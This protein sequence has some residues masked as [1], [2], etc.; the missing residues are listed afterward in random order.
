MAKRLV[1]RNCIP[2]LILCSSAKRTQETA[3]YF[4][5]AFGFGE[6]KLWV[7]KSLYLCTPETMLEQLAIAESG[8]RHIMIIAHNP[9]LEQLSYRLSA[10][11][12]PSMP[13]LG[14]RHFAC[15]SLN[16]L[17]MANRSHGSAAKSDTNIELV[18][19]DFPKNV[20]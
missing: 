8:L 13:T 5:E 9:G 17:P 3:A 6:D 15:S 2:D 12:N 4:T 20:A 19:E 16:P 7:S 11:C 18:F 10:A 14:V 1:E